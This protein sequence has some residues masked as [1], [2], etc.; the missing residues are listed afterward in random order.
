MQTKPKIILLT[1][2]NLGPYHKARYQLLSQGE[3]ELVIAKMPLKEHFRPWQTVNTEAEFQ[4]RTPFDVRSNFLSILHN[5][6]ALIKNEKPSVVTCVGYY[7]K[8]V[9]VT[10]LVCKFFGTPCVLYLVG[11]GNENTRPQLK[12]LFKRLY[13]K[14]LFDASGSKRGNGIRLSCGNL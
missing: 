8:Y 13:V 2:Y 5:A 12:E 6:F 11:W 7:G 3:I 4:V 9:W 10:S 1:H 14:M